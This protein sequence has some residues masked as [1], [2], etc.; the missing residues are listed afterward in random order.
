MS[1]NN[2]VTRLNSFQTKLIEKYYEDYGDKHIASCIYKVLKYKPDPNS[3]EE[4]IGVAE[5]AICKAAKNFQQTKGMKFSSFVQM[6]IMSS[7]TT[8]IRDN[9]TKKRRPVG[10]VDSLD[11][12]VNTETGVTFGDLIEYVEHEE[13]ISNINNISNYV[14]SLSRMETVIL[15]LRLLGVQ[16]SEI[17]ENLSEPKFKIKDWH[18]SVSNYEKKNIIK[19]RGAK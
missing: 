9:N 6:N 7:I 10:G 17:L 16:I 18:N 8:Y 11:R 3:M 13:V 4:Y 15:V 14:K 19:R 5:E 2:S 12:V 1:K